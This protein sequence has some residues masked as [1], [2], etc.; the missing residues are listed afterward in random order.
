MTLIPTQGTFRG[1]AAVSRTSHESSAEP[2]RS[3]RHRHHGEVVA[4]DCDDGAIQ[5]GDGCERVC[6]RQD[7]PRSD[8]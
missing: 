7:G 5:A 3:T 2:S 6:A 1:L 8:R 4:L